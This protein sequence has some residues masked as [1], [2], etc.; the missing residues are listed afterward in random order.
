MR[1]GWLLGWAVP[2]EWFA[3][4]AR[5]A[6]PTAEH[7]FV[8]AVPGA[9]DQL[10]KAGPFDW[11]G[12]YSLGALL[13]LCESARAER[14][15]RIALLAPIFA[16]PCEAELGGRVAHGQM[17]QLARWLRR[18]A[19]TALADFYLRAGLDVSPASAP[20]ALDGLLWGLESLANDRRAPPL[21]LG[22]RA[23]CGTDDALLDADRLHAFAPSVQIVP[24]ATHH[25][26]ALLRAFAAEATLPASTR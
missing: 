7:V 21:P 17:R 14:L 18:D 9:L 6:F 16:F 1:I 22:W 19:R 12:G 24:G 4:L 5:E 20:T 2:E 15:G 10:E 11:V 25:P 8:G 13:L 23:W 3:S 26:G